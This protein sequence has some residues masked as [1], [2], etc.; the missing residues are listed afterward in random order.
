MTLPEFFRHKNVEDEIHGVIENVE[1]AARHDEDVARPLPD[2]IK[3]ER[4]SVPKLLSVVE[5]NLR[6]HKYGETHGGCQQHT[7]N[8]SRP[9]KS[10]DYFVDTAYPL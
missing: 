9:R 10:E 6:Q 5:D 1:R 8:L 7:V 4:A 3:A 2:K